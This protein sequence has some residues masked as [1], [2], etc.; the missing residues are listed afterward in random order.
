MVTPSGFDG[1]LLAEGTRLDGETS[2]IGNEALTAAGVSGCAPRVADRPLGPGPIIATVVNTQTAV[3][4][5]QI[6]LMAL[7]PECPRR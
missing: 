7:P 5:R 6:V 2:G 4:L 1:G 3:R